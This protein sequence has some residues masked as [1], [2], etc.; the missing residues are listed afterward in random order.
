VAYERHS[1]FD[2]PQCGGRAKKGFPLV[3]FVAGWGTMIRNAALPRAQQT[4]FWQAVRGCTVW[5]PRI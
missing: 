5:F 4:R 1:C 3:R 2:E